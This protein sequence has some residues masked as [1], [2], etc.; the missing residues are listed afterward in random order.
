MGRQRPPLLL[1]LLQVPMQ[2]MTRA[3]QGWLRLLRAAR[4]R[5][6][7]DARLLLLLLLLLLRCLRCRHRRPLSW[8]Q[9]PRSRL[10]LLLPCWRQVGRGCPR[11]PA[12]P[13]RQVGQQVLCIGILY[14]NPTLLGVA[15]GGRAGGDDERAAG[16]VVAAPAQGAALL[17]SWLSRRSGRPRAR[18]PPPAPPFSPP[19]H[20]IRAAHSALP[21]RSVARL[22]STHSAR[23]A[24]VM[25]TFRRR[26]SLTKP[27]VGERKGGRA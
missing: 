18:A 22:P 16:S 11:V 12:R 2:R 3:R 5:G 8:L 23:L 14:D 15:A 25:A 20:L 7:R 19:P 26:T 27:V 21:A 10:L 1:Q 4:L 9:L 24:R 6:V 13:V 17:Q